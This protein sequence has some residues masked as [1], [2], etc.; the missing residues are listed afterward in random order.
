MSGLN[1]EWTVIL[2]KVEKLHFYVETQT[3]RSLLPR[4]FLR[5]L[6]VSA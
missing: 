5:G 1:P 4:A 6:R 2:A 3:T